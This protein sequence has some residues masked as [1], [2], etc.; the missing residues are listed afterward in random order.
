[1]K[2]D[3]VLAT[4]KSLQEA[5]NAT[6]IDAGNI[7]RSARSET[8]THSATNGNIYNFGTWQPRKNLQ[9]SQLKNGQIST[10]KS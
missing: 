10:K 3:K 5:A 8:R 9:R 7:G 4:Y 1:M 2:D 6:G